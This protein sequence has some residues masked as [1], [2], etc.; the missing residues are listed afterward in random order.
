MLWAMININ[1]CRDRTILTPLHV[2]N[3]N[4]DDPCKYGFAVGGQ[5]REG[6]FMVFRVYHSTLRR[7]VI[8]R[9]NHVLARHKIRL[10]R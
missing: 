2:Y 5:L 10:S 9:Y 4:I 1:L 7:V 8:I 6:T 3:P